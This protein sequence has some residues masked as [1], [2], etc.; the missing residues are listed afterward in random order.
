VGNCIDLNHTQIFF[1]GIFI[2]LIYRLFEFLCS[3]HSAR[4]QA[5]SQHGKPGSHKQMA[6]DK[7]GANATHHGPPGSAVT[8]S[9]PAVILNDGP[10]EGGFFSPD[11]GWMAEAKDWAGAL[12]SGQS[13]TGR[14]LVSGWNGNGMNVDGQQQEDDDN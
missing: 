2:V 5:Q 8:I 7:M 6:G 4:L 11:L 13:T 14:I 12:I 1:A 3:G 9:N 10:A